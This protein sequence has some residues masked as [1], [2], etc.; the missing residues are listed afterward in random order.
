MGKSSI[1]KQHPDRNVSACCQ[2]NNKQ[3]SHDTRR[4]YH[5]LTVPANK[6][7]IATGSAGLVT[8]VTGSS[9]FSVFVCLAGG[10]TPVWAADARL[11]LEQ[12]AAAFGV[13]SS[14]RQASLSPD[15][16]LLATVE[17]VGAGGADVRILDL[18]RADSPTSRDRRSAGRPGELGWCRWSGT[19]RLLCNVY[20]V[21]SLDSV[22]L[23]Y[24][25][26]PIAVD[27]DGKRMQ[28]IRIP[29]TGRD[30]LGYRLLGGSVLDWNTGR[31]GHVLLLRSYVPEV[32]TGTRLAHTDD[33]LGVDHI[34]TVS[35][36][37]VSRVERARPVNKEFISDGHGCIRIRGIDPALTSGHYSFGT[38][39]ER[40]KGEWSGWSNY[41][42]QKDFIGSGPHIEQGSPARQAGRI[43]A[44]V[45]MFHGTFDRNV[46]VGQSRLMADRLRQAGKDGTLVV[47]EQLDHYLDDSEARRDMLVQSANFLQK[48]LNAAP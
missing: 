33:G 28:T 10:V 41:Y 15:G 48:A 24:I 47:Y 8:R 36:R 30:A 5:G 12:A 21:V 45:L 22:E 4:C 34:D 35:L 16:V 29:G 37:T 46:N 44:P 23:S 43:K 32:L 20:G 19:S 42:L 11:E 2:F 17:G 3:P 39:L 6:G 18:T 26:R 9:L 7:G 13:R 14:V 27:A 25:S 31:D 1:N 40:L 38:D